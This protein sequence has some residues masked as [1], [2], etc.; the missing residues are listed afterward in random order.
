VDTPLAANWINLSLGILNLF[1]VIAAFVA[2]GMNRAQADENWRHTQE[3][4]LDERQH[5][6]R[7]IIIPIGE[8]V[9]PQIQS[10]N[11]NAAIQQDAQN[12]IKAQGVYW[13]STDI[14]IDLCNIGHG[15]ALK[16]YP[17][18]ATLAKMS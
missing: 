15:P 11:A 9:F 12:Q 4:A 5:Q 7:P 14:Q 17:K 16:A 2:I 6:S 1:I 13:D 10:S 18:T 8:I 3:L